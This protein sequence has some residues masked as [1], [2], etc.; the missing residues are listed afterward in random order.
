MFQIDKNGG[1]TMHKGNTGTV[2]VTLTG[3]TFGSADRAVFAIRDRNGLLIKQIISPIES[4]H[5]DFTL[6]NTD[7][8]N[9]DPGRYRWGVTVVTDPTY[10]GGDIVDGSAVCTPLKDLPLY[11][12]DPAALV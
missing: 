4:G 12:L 10:D 2:R 11:L 9:T 8:D 7:T 5:A 1:L 3:Y 6:V